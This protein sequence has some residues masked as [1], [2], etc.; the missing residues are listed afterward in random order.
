M[1]KKQSAYR[2]F[3][4]YPAGR[5]A[6]QVLPNV[7]GKI[8]KTR[9]ARPDS[10]DVIWAEVVGPKYAPYTLVDKWENHTLFI[11]V[12]SATLLNILVTEGKAHLL[13]KLKQ[14]MPN[15]FVRDIV[16]RR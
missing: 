4:K 6:Q 12:K 13:Q 8:T 14:K 11:K 5:T 9:Q 15:T 10:I 7:L 3:E 2:N 1:K 16:F